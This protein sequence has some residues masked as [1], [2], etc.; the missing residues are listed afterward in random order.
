M[1][2]VAV[3]CFDRNES[4]LRVRVQSQTIHTGVE[5]CT[6]NFCCSCHFV[7]SDGVYSDVLLLFCS[8]LLCFRALTDSQKGAFPFVIYFSVSVFQQFFPWAACVLSLGPVLYRA[9]KNLCVSYVVLQEEI[10]GP[11][12]R[13]SVL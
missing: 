12:A 1:V 2:A 4:T 6:H 10:R 11:H 13:W 5:C 7:V 8:C 3:S 9:Y